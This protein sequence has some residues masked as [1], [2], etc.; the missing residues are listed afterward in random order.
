[1]AQAE[2]AREA[3][4]PQP[5]RP[6][7]QAQ[8][9]AEARPVLRQA[10]QPAE[11]VDEATADEALDDALEQGIADDDLFGD[12]TGAP[13]DPEAAEEDWGPDGLW[14]TEDDPPLPGA[15]TGEAAEEPVVPETELEATM[16]DVAHEETLTGE[17]HAGVAPGHEGEEEAVE[18]EEAHFDGAVFG[19]QLLNFLVWLAIVVL[20]LRKP[21]TEFLRSRRLAVE[22]GL[23]EAQ[24]LEEE[25]QAKYDDYSER[26]ERLDE[27]LEKLRQEMIQAGESERDRIIAEAESRAAR[28]R[29]DAQFIIDQQLKQ[30]R[31]DLTREAIEAAI[32]AAERVLT[33]Q[34]S[35]ADQQKLAEAY[36]ERLEEEVR[37]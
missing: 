32:S 18:H 24:R 17:E 11:P 6:A 2:P 35:S 16:E 5:R 13:E 25:A 28:M 27:E 31:S 9:E 26:L 29:R 3:P 21:L 33:E 8:E 14:G 15:E 10:P 30:M 19:M 12:P 36:L 20:L 22:E 4:A 23:V 7:P 34:T 1:P 37:A